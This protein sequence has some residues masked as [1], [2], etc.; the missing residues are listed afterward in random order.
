MAGTQTKILGINDLK[1]IVIQQDDSATF[2]VASTGGARE[3]IDLP[4][5]QTLSLTPTFVEKEL[6]GDEVVLDKYTKLDS[7]NWSFTN[8]IMSLTALEALLGGSVSGTTNKTFTLT[9]LDLPKYF[10]LEGQAEYTDEGD[11]HVRLYKAKANKVDYELKGE[12]YAVVNVSGM[13]IPTQC[14]VWNSV[15]ENGGRV[16]EI[17]INEVVTPI[18]FSDLPM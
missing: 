11:I 12:D 9:G 2:R 5:V 15:T 10:V 8:A 3:V 17:T 4:G 14:N 16:K 1:L 7:I 6:R 13:A 18:N